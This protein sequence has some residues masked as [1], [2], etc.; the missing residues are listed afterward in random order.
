M[1]YRCNRC[2]YILYIYRWVGPKCTVVTPFN[3]DLCAT[4]LDNYCILD[5]EYS[6]LL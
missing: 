3:L 1:Y 4:A 6:F 5:I 2:I